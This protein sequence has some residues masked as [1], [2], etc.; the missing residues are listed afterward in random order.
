[1]I[2]MIMIVTIIKVF[3]RYK[4]LS[5]ETIL[6][7]CTCVHACIHARTHTHTHTQTI[8]NLIYTQLKTGSKQTL[9]MDEEVAEDSNMGTGME[10]MAGP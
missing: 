6:S 9:E 8:Q 3:I 7:I 2:F 5:V 1:M 10:N 4:I